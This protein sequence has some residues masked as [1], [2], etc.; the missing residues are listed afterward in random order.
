MLYAEWNSLVSHFSVPFISQAFF[1]E[2]SESA[3]YRT[4]SKLCM[5]D[6]TQSDFTICV[7]RK[8][9]GDPVLPAIMELLR[10]QDGGVDV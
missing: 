2:S 8:R 5:T 4:E 7:K 10:W 1:Y 6:Y 9:T 3:P